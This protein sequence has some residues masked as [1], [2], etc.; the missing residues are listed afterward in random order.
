VTKDPDDTKFLECADVA[1]CDYVV[2]GNLRHFPVFWK[3]T[4]VISS[5]DFISLVAPHLIP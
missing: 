3:K 4:K 5:R 1:R 2:T